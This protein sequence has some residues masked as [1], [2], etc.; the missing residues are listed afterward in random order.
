MD[1]RDPAILEVSPICIRLLVKMSIKISLCGRLPRHKA[2]LGGMQDVSKPR[3]AVIDV[4]RACARARLVSALQA[5]RISCH[6]FFFFYSINAKISGR[7]R[8]P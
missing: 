1:W 8:Q 6:V 7:D 2:D 4:A 3:E 5:T